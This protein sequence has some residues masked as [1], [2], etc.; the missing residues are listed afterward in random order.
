MRRGEVNKLEGAFFRAAGK[1]AVCGLPF[2][3]PDT[4]HLARAL[5]LSSVFLFFPAAL[6]SLLVWAGLLVQRPGGSSVKVTS[7]TLERRFAINT[8]G[9]FPEVPPPLLTTIAWGCSTQRCFFLRYRQCEDL[10][11]TLE[12]ESYHGVPHEQI[13]C[14]HANPAA[15][16][17]HSNKADTNGIM[18]G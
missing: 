15:A 18:G 9:R 2:F 7:I 4:F 10:T 17:L 3:A 13:S 11:G 16:A 14:V 8:R 6:C 5:V 1:H 12:A